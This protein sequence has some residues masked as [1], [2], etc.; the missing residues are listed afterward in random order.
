[1]HRRPL[2][3]VSVPIL[4]LVLVVFLLYTVRSSA[5]PPAPSA[6]SFAPT[7]AGAAVKPPAPAPPAE[8]GP[9]ETGPA[10]A[11]S[12]V[13][14]GQPAPPAA[15]A[16]T[17]EAD[18]IVVVDGQALRRDQFALVQAVDG[19]MSDLLGAPPAPPAQ[20]LDQ[21]INHLL[22]QQQIT[23][24]GG[25]PAV[26]APSRLAALLDAAGKTCL[27]YTSRCV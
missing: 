13:D 25:A 27:L 17:P 24:A 18:L 9:A 11:S 6:A 19:V 20:L 12:L 15:P 7:L 3:F 4:A 22:V 5:Q 21:A 14:A 23:A 1:M 8:T 10:G 16:V 2:F 26:A